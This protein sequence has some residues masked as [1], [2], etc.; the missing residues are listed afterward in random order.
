MGEN[1]LLMHLIKV[2]IEEVLKAEMVD[3]LLDVAYILPKTRRL[4]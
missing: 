3:F 4:V 2:L 1:T